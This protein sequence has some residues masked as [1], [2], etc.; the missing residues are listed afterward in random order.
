MKISAVSQNNY[1][2]QSFGLRI[3]NIV[4]G[5]MSCAYFQSH[6]IK[7]KPQIGPKTVERLNR[8]RKMHPEYRL[9]TYLDGSHG[10]DYYRFFVTPQDLNSTCSKEIARISN[11]LSPVVIVAKLEQALKK[12][13]P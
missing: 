12:F 2:Q 4:D 6:H 3:G 1:H 13:K 5:I 7:G 8:I 10:H 11:K 9:T